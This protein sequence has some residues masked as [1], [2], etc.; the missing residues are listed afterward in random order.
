MHNASVLCTVLCTVQCVQCTVLCAVY[1][2]VL[3]YSVWCP[4]RCVL[5]CPV[6]CCAAWFLNL[7]RSVGKAC[8]QSYELVGNP[9][10]NSNV[11][12]PVPASSRT[13]TWL[14]DVEENTVTFRPRLCHANSAGLSFGSSCLSINTHNAIS[15]GSTSESAT[16]TRGKPISNCVIDQLR[17]PSFPTHAL[18]CILSGGLATGEERPSETTTRNVK[19]NGSLLADDFC[20]NLEAGAGRVGCLELQQTVHVRSVPKVHGL[21]NMRQAG[22]ASPRGG[23]LSHAED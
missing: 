1:C 17:P 11:P 20:W 21:L 16:N 4:V 22:G 6:L 12:C 8:T 9:C 7:V 10:T 15:A 18:N 19:N 2:A 3:R 14:A 13:K 23:K 5:C